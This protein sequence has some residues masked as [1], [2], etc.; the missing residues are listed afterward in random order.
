[1]RVVYAGIHINPCYTI[2]YNLWHRVSIGIGGVFGLFHS[3]GNCQT[4][5][6][7]SGP[8]QGRPTS[9]AEWGPEIQGGSYEKY[10]IY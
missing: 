3:R 7:D 4:C 6:S 10:K 2:V 8:L 1:M 9:K 5:A